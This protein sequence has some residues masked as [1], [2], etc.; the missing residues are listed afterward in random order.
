MPDRHAVLKIRAGNDRGHA[1]HG[2][3]ESFH[4]FSFAD[5]FD[6]EHNGFRNLRVLNEDRVAPGE[7]FGRHPHRDME[8][9]SYVLDGALAHEDSMGTGSVI[10]PGE[11]Q[12]MSAGTGVTHSETNASST[13]PVHFLQIWILPSQRGVAPS[14][15]QRRLDLEAHRGRLRVIASGQGGPGRRSGD[16]A[17][18]EDAVTIHADARVLA[19]RFAEG[20]TDVLPL[21]DGRHAWVHVARGRVRVNGVSLGAGDA[22]ALSDEREIKIEGVADGEVLVFDL[23]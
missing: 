1:R 23:P 7:G 13:E 4:T 16:G 17:I 19:G 22:A 5:Y 6:P 3:L 12:R 21:A 15:E 10:R 9:L 11:I 20:S 14:Y 18:A 2:W 8:I